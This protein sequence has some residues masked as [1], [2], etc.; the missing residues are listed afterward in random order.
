[1]STLIAAA[2]HYSRTTLLILLF[3]LIGGFIAVQKIP[4]EANPDVAIPLIYISIPYEG[5][6]PEDAVRLLLRPMEKELQSIEGVKEMRSLGSE[7][8]ASITLEFNAGFDSQQALQ[9]VR[10]KVDTAK[11]KLP[12][13]TEEPSIHEI[14]VAL[15][16]VINIALSSDLAETQI[17]Q[18]A[19]QL[20]ND[21]EGLSG[22]LEVEIGGEREHLMEILIDPQKLETYQLDF[23]KILQHISS[24]NQLVAA[25]AIEALDGRQVI[26]VPG[27]VE[28]LEDMLNM[29]LASYQ[30][31]VLHFRDIA[32]LSNTFKDPQSFARVNQQP[33]LV[34]SVK[35]KVGANIIATLEEVR[36]LVQ[37]HQSLWPAGQVQ[38]AYLLDQ[39]K[40]IH[41]MLKDLFN[42]VLSG[43]ILV[44]L[45]VLATMGFKSSWLV[46]LA[47]P[48]SF[49]TGIFILYWMGITLNI[50][51]LFSLILV[52]GM[53]V[54]GAIVV[55][56]L[57][58]RKM[59]TGTHARQAFTYAA[60]RM[61]WPV[62]TATAT[63]LVVFMPLLFWPGVVG[64]FMSYLPLSVLICLS[65]SLFMALIFIPVLGGVLSQSPTSTQVTTP[66]GAHLATHSTDAH[67]WQLPAGAFNQAYRT[68]LTSLLAHPWKTFFVSLF[69]LLAT[70]VAY[71]V[72]GKGVE[73][74]PE[75]DPDNVLV[76]LHARGD[77]SIQQKDALLAQVEAR[78]A[79]V[80]YIRSLYARSF[81]APSGEM[82]ED[83]IAEIQV[84][85]VDW[86]ERPRAQVI[87]AEFERLTQDMAGFEL[88]F[89]QAEEGPVQGK[90]IQVEVSALNTTSLYTSVHKVR[91]LMQELGGFISVEDNRPLPG[92]EWRLQVDRSEAMRY[93]ADVALIG[94][95]IQLMT[96][97]IKLS[98]F[99]PDYADDEVDIRLR[100]PATERH[101]DALMQMQVHTPVGR[102]PLSHFVHLEPAPKVGNIHR[103]QGRQVI[104]VQADA[105]QGYLVSERV[106]ALA[107]AFSQHNWPADIKLNFKGEDEQQ[108]ETADFLSTAF[109]VALFLMLLILVTQFNSLYQ[110]CLVLSAI[111]FSTAGVLLGLLITGQAFGVVMVG[112]GIIALA[113]IVVNN[114][115]VLIDT[116]R[117]L[118]QL[119]PPPQAALITGSVR[120][121]PVL[122]TAGTTILGLMPMVLGMNLDILEAQIDLGAPSTQWW[123][124]LASAIA[125]GL[126]FATLLTLFL[127]PALL[128]LG[129][130]LFSQSSAA[131]SS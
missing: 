96:Q 60:S 47:I 97:G 27:V 111:V 22:V 101:L 45:V 120:L 55:I 40:I 56:E 92:I 32:Q 81:Q 53:L 69:F 103:T 63:T 76:R 77:L 74:F 102:V 78:I 125:G 119:H 12:A 91:Q 58:D 59:Q 116:Y 39:S 6:S 30:G 29:P 37:A 10:E 89:R 4:K 131:P 52:V 107:Q 43:V 17:L 100:Y 128:V 26:K 117:E 35:K 70:Y 7:G 14:N 88:E 84:E 19:R 121:R 124:Q 73:F 13:A 129:E 21:L 65:A 112:V 34:L 113:G 75:V 28:D 130:S 72:W 24:N 127:T 5:I 33:A 8:H 57:A 48:S 3:L 44:M 23:A 66:S 42:N 115:I 64:E 36:T 41:T 95:S 87:L 68:I 118:R 99:R 11:T 61:A 83:V 90:P 31:Q 98:D 20:K 106:Q 123:T 82:A 86:Q 105:A 93:Q 25:G 110:A 109:G 51:V 122:L 114:N 104:K 38:V 85:L 108:Q 67:P 49:L 15:F 62:I 2:M 94:Q 46:G 71:G 126:A 16:P 80:P 79:P 18:L 1:M 50:V 54:D 9:D